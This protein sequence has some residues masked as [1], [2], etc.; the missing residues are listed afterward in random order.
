MAFYTEEETGN[1]AYTDLKI[2]QLPKGASVIFMK[3][4]TT[5]AESKDFGKFTIWQG[6]SFDIN[7][8][9]VDEAIASLKLTSIVPNKLIQ[10]KYN[11]QAIKNK[12]FYKYEKAW[13]KGELYDKNKRAKGFGFKVMSLSLP[14]SL[15]Q[16]AYE[17]HEKE[18][19]IPVPNPTLNLEGTEADVDT[20][21]SEI[22]NPTTPSSKVNI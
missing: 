19:T 15:I 14:D 4:S 13:E 5:S 16:A 1:S 21:T 20:F 22:G 3:L 8:G 7:A 17:F 11:N 9:S 18:L 10:S 2:T 6:V 12:L